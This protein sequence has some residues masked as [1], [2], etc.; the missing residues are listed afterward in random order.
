MT[1][2]HGRTRVAAGV[3]AAFAIGVPTA[4]AQSGTTTTTTPSTTTT[5]STPTAAPATTT[6]T[7]TAPAVAAGPPVLRNL[8]LA[9]TITARQGHARFLVGVRLST[10]AK[11]IVQVTALKGNQ[12]VKTITSP[13]TEN[14]GRVY[15][16]VEA[17]NNQ[18]FQLPEGRYRVTVQATDAQNRTAKPLERVVTLTLTTPRGRLDADLVPLWTP[19][20][21]SLGLPVGKGT[22]VGALAPRGDMIKAGLRRSDVITAINGKP[23]LSSGQLAVALRAL[24]A[25]TPVTID[26]RRG[27]DTRSATLGAPAD[28]NPAPDLSSAYAVILKRNPKQLAAAVQAALYQA[29]I[30]K[31]DVAQKLYAA[32]PAS[33]KAMAPGQFVAAKIAERQKDA[34]RALGAYNRA[35]QRDPRMSEAA[36]GRGLSFNT[37][38]KD[39]Y[40]AQAFQQAFQLDPGDPSAG[41]FQAFSLIRADRNAE[42]L[43]PANAAAALDT[44][45]AD[46]LI[47]QGIA[48]IRTGHVARGVVALRQG[49]VLTDDGARSQQIIDE[50]LE[51]NDK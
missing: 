21:R 38:G 35:L 46:G 13:A 2:S 20:A 18:N 31:P 22:L 10:P 15:V 14:P 4:L 25:T 24:P 17:T 12:L 26:F 34:T 1:A 40:A 41:A 27:S 45:Y 23:T 19:L 39:A 51:P 9:S 48:Q 11:V 28:W 37:L 16:M 30:G 33:W 44:D 8:K 49:L 7:T 32:W 43:A 36:F 5:G 42:S 47:A 50:Y 3:A 29:K 6:P